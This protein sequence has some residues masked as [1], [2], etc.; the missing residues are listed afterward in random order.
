[1]SSVRSRQAAQSR[2][3][4]IATRPAQEGLCRAWADAFGGKYPRYAFMAGTTANAVLVGLKITEAVYNDKIP[5]A[6]VKGIE[7]DLVRCQGILRFGELEDVADVVGLLCRE[8]LR[9]MT[10]SVIYADEGAMSILYWLLLRNLE[11]IPQLQAGSLKFLLLP[12]VR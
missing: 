10:S 2:L 1:M 5:E 4:Y 12:W 8:E 11:I 6:V 3:L 9:W 7:N